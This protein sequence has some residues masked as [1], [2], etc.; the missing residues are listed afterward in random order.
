MATGG[1]G[2]CRAGF[3]LVLLFQLHV[4][5]G[6][7]IMSNGGDDDDVATQV[8]RETME[9]VTAEHVEDM[10]LL[11]TIHQDDEVALKAEKEATMPTVKSTKSSS[12]KPKSGFR[13]PQGAKEMMKKRD[14]REKVVSSP[15]HD[16]RSR[17]P[18]ASRPG[19]A[20]ETENVAGNT[21][22]FEEYTSSMIDDDDEN[23]TGSQADDDNGEGYDDDKRAASR[24]LLDQPT[25]ALH[26]SYV[27][28]V[29]KASGRGESI[30]GD[31]GGGDLY[32]VLGVKKGES[33]VSSI[34]RQV[35]V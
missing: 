4:L 5:N 28:A 11:E 1:R 20:R 35:C 22:T 6:D 13:S 27:E 30:Y 14:L 23:I 29:L 34:K 15:M 2:V 8:L 21:F 10:T 12:S 19:L 25:R 16:R 31:E 24:A 7:S 33:D 9:E 26:R 18:E 17:V 32:K 3:I